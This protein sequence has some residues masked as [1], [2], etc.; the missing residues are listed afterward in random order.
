MLCCLFV[1]F[2]PLR[3]MNSFDWMSVHS[4]ATSFKAI[5]HN[6]QYVCNPMLSPIT[7]ARNI[8]DLQKYQSSFLYFHQLEVSIFLC[9]P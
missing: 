6:L 7:F 8:E 9:I 2:K 4:L 3:A 5:Y 1:S